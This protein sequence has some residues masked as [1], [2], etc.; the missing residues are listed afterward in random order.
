MARLHSFTQRLGALY[1]VLLP[2][3]RIL[4]LPDLAAHLSAAG[5]R[6]Q[7]RETAVLAG[8]PLF[9]AGAGTLASG[10]LLPWVSHALG[11]RRARSFIAYASYGGAAL[12]LLTFTFVRNP[13]WAIAV[14]SLSSFA[15]ELSTPVTWI[16]AMDL[17]GH[18]V[19]TLTGAMNAIGQIGASVAPIVIGYVLTETRN[20]WT[21]TFYISTVIYAMGIGAGLPLIRSHPLRS[22]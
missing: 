17:G 9:F 21:L 6:L 1:S 20:N 13:L 8:M 4:F 22:K 14:M 3:L 2:L 5:Q 18:A 11:K 19:G 10:F 7:R 15:V 12:L 16:T